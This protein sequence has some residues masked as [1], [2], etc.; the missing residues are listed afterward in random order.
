[1]HERGT[2]LLSVS[3][4]QPDE[5]RAMNPVR[6]QKEKNDDVQHE[7]GRHCPVVQ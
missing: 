5:V 4:A 3:H 7:K 2:E 1:M 6:T